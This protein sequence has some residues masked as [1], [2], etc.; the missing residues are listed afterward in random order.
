MRR[1]PLRSIAALAVLACFA[2]APRARAGGFEVPDQSAVVGA[3]GGAGTAR[4]GD[5]SAAFYNPAAL[6]DQ[7]GFR[8]G[9]GI[10][11][12]V[13]TISIEHLEGGME[14]ATT[15]SGVS[16]PP[17]LHLSYA[18]NEWAFGAYV[19]VSHGTSVSWPS[20]PDAW[21][22]RFE[23]MSTGLLVIR[24]APFFSLRLGG[25]RGL[26]RDFPDVRLSIG[27]H[28][29]VARAETRRDLD[30]ID[31][32]GSV[33]VLMWGAGVGGDASLYWQATPELA[34][35]LSYK[36]RTWMRLSG[37]ADF[38]VPDP[39]VGRAPDQQASTELVV[40]DR[41]TLGAAWQQREFGI[42]ADVGFTTW[43]VRDVQ[44]VDFSSENTSD[45]VTP[46]GWRDT[47][48]FRLGGEVSPIDWFRARAG[49]YY[50]ME[51]SPAETLGP[52]SPDMARFGVTVGM[53][54]DITREIGVDASYSYVTFIG[55][56][57]T[58]QDAPLARY[59]GDLHVVAL[60]A[61]VVVG[62]ESGAEREAEAEAEAATEAET[63]AESATE[64]EAETAT[65]TAE[66]EAEV[67]PG[68]G[69]RAR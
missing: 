61:R 9:L 29:D 8:G 57:S 19:G 54:F 27:A 38:T 1:S 55:R 43:S 42:F 58:S 68:R 30:F 65:P 49:L 24:A 2:P 67:V 31:V 41:L 17:H 26:L 66:P 64:A 7:G 40:P 63:E 60:T 35:G 25:E 20:A 37:D 16:P 18:E 3:T 5:P 23:A 47:W 50:D 14:T 33:H 51:A 12:A 15:V 32:Q 48:A 56:E 52:A 45:S 6:A 10:L 4:R 44:R 11:L 62:G 21:W 46:Q 69:R 39:F 36:S 22:G 53:G 28:V 34:F 13:P 59:W